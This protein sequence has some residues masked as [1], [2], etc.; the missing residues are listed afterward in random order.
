MPGT[1]WLLYTLDGH[2]VEVLARETESHEVVGPLT[3]SDGHKRRFFV[4][5]HEVLTRL[6]NDRVRLQIKFTVWKHPD[7]DGKKTPEP[8][9]MFK[10]FGAPSGRTRSTQKYREALKKVSPIA[11]NDPAAKGSHHRAARS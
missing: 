8:V 6:W 1:V 10:E 2:S 3:C 9:D 7:G 11:K 4:S 5:T